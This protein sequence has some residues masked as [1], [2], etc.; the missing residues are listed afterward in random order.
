MDER[1]TWRAEKQGLRMIRSGM[2]VLNR[3]KVVNMGLTEKVAFEEMHKQ[4]R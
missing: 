1:N 2:V 3:G 4:K